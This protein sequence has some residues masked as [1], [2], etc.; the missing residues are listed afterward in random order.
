[1]DQVFDALHVTD[2]HFDKDLMKHAVDGEKCVRECRENDRKICF[3]NFTLKH[4]QILGGWVK[5]E[6]R[7]N[8]IK[9][10]F[11]LRSCYDCAD[12][13]ADSCLNE[14]CVVGDG[15]GRGYLAINFKLPGPQIQVCKNDIVVVDVHNEAEGLS[16]TLHWHGMRQFGTQFMDGVPYFTQ[17][18]VPFGE[19]FRYSFYAIDEGLIESNL[20][21]IYI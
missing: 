11:S 7:L 6:L 13:N 17:C 20:C 10:N 18:P 19:S 9:L 14:E 12:G 4:Y 15:I 2:R 1:M 5:E 8:V 16:T 21:K 3:Y